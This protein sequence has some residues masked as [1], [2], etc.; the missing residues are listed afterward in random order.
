[1]MIDA[2][3]ADSGPLCADAE[4]LCCCIWEV[5]GKPL[6]SSRLEETSDGVFSVSAVRLNT[7][8]QLQMFDMLVG[9]IFT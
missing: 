9:T 4:S 1:M 7:E 6:G 5:C 2:D 8:M 3:A